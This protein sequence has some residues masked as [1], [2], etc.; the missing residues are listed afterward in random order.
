MIPLD[1]FIAPIRS[2]EIGNGWDIH[3]YFPL[4]RIEF[5][6]E[7]RDTVIREFGEYPGVKVYRLWDKPIGPHTLPMFEVDV[8]SPA[9]FGAVLSW[10]GTH[11]DGLSVLVHPHTDPANDLRNHLENAMWMGEKLPLKVETLQG[12]R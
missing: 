9:E 10:I 4:E 8:F 7:L 12:S 2:S 11:R 3:I 5:A 6:S 1:K